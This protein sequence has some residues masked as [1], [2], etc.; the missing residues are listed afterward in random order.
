[1]KNKAKTGASLLHKILTGVFAILFLVSMIGGTLA[2]NYS[3][4]IN[5]VLDTQTTQVPSD[6][7]Q[8]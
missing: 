1:M 8:T 2:H 4:I 7:G 6:P 5:M 3:P